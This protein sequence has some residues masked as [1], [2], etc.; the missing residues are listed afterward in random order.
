MQPSLPPNTSGTARL[1][2]GPLGYQVGWQEPVYVPNPG[3]GL[4]WVHAVDGRYFERVLSVTFIFQASAA[5]SN[6]FIQLQYVDTNGNAITTV[7]ASGQ[8]TAGVGVNANM[9]INAPGY[10]F[11]TSN[12]T[13]GFIPD[14]LLPPGWAIQT[15][16]SGIDVADQYSGIV[17]LVQRFPNDAA[18]IPAGY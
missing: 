10:N 4:G 17:L 16:N 6:R 18:M 7:P 14:L 8:I 13:G 2:L 12:L 11:G 5:V 9:S 3:A 1:I 15:H